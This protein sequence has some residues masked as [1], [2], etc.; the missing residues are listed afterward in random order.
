MRTTEARQLLPDAWGFICPVHTPDGSPC[1]L[2]NHLTIDCL[3]SDSP[4]KTL[5]ENI[6][7]ILV[8]LGMVPLNTMKINYKKHFVVMLEGRVIGH[9]N[10]S[11]AE[12]I[13]VELRLL[14]IEGKQMPK[15]TEIVL[16]PDIKVL[17]QSN[18]FLLFSQLNS[19]DF[20][21]ILI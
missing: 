5:V 10:K 20:P 18:R 11:M 16:V 8:N 13:C 15:F 9:L 4:D 7:N 12:Q 21:H 1:G 17:L 2:L 19:F 14:K 6:P 3:V